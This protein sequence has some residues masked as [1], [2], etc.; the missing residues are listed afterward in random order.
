MQLQRCAVCVSVRTGTPANVMRRLRFS[1][2]LILGFVFGIPAGLLIGLLL[3][4]ARGPDQ[5]GATSLQVQ[6]LTRKLEALQEE[7]QRADRQLEQ[8]ERLAGQMT[9]SFSSLEQ[10][11][12]ALEEEQRMRET[13][14]NQPPAQAPPMQA[15]ATP[16]QAGQAPALDQQPEAE[17]GEPAQDAAPD[18]S[19][20][21]L[22]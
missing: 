8:F 1:S 12:K 16:A 20:P 13:R 9:A 5:S 22:Q 19:A 6:E 14:R 3:A 21:E 4:P 17:A 10:R 11:F 7:K 15:P 18:P 2:G